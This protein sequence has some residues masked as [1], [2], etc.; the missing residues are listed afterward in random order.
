MIILSD[1][2]REITR[3]A[4]EIC[5]LMND[6]VVGVHHILL[7]I[8]KANPVLSKIFNKHGVTFS[9]FRAVAKDSL[10]AF[11]EDD[12]PRKEKVAD[13][14]QNRST[15]VKKLAPAADNKTQPI[16]EKELL[17]KYCR[18]LTALASQGKL[19]PV[20]GREKEIN[21]LVTTLGRHKKNNAILVGEPGVG[22]TAIVEGLAQRIFSG[23]VPPHVKS[24]Q[25]FQLNM[26]SVVSKT[27]YRGQFEERMKAIMDI[28]SQH[29]DFILF[30][31]EIHTL[32]GSGGSIGG[33][34]AAN[35]MKPALANGDL[36]CVGATT[37]DEYR[38]YFKKDGALD[39]RFQRVFVNEP[40]KEETVNI[41]IGIKP[42]IEK[43]HNCVISDDVCRLAVNLSMRYMP[44][45]CLPDKAIDCM[46]EACA[47]AVSKH[48]GKSEEKVHIQKSDVVEAIATQADM[49]EEIVGVSDIN[50]AKSLRSF[51]ESKV[52]GQD[53]AI[54]SISNVLLSAY[55]GIKNPKKPIGCFVFGGP[56]GAG[57]SLMAERMADSLFSSESSIVRISMSEFSE[58]F[59]NTKLIGSPPGYTGY[60]DKNQLTDKVSRRPYCLVLI[61]G[62]EN[63]KDDVVRLFTQAMAKG[64]ITD[65]SGHDVS[66]RNTIIVMTMT[67]D[68]NKSSK[69]GFDCGSDDSVLHREELVNSCR[70]RFGDDF[71]NCIDDFVVFRELGKED[72]RRV[73]VIKLGELEA[74]MKEANVSLKFSDEVIDM[75]VDESAKNGVVPSMETLDRYIRRHIEAIVSQTLADSKTSASCLSLEV[76][77]GKLRCSVCV[78]AEASV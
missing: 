38:K 58:Q 25:V 57:M 40:T 4:T 5:E 42:I 78:E 74:R 13:D 70:D 9:K 31:D 61:E 72:I 22:K 6:P 27:T 54:E 15:G 3:I 20:I 17:S 29:K 21:R 33:L 62:I 10:S 37:E 16:N 34:D 14:H 41:L 69:I 77:S 60:G 66:F 45:R 46:D 26:T 11:S 30:V 44:D 51:L 63:S 71:T 64:F 2:G 35:I 49:S 73:A 56:A 8:L 19:D 55:A 24:N 36:R 48:N 32:I 76:K 68:S 59:G 50:R 52:V 53:H 65:A 18:N 7:A 39:R 75:I 28:F 43:H 1:G 47:N 67:M 23:K 12:D